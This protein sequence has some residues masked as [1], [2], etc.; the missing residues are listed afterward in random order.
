M[1]IRRALT[2]AVLLGISTAGL[3]PAAEKPKGP[4]APS[5]KLEAPESALATTPVTLAATGSDPDKNDTLRYAWRFDDGVEASGATVTRAFAA[6]TWTATVTVTDR[7]KRTATASAKLVVTPPPRGAPASEVLGATAT[8][9]KTPPTLAALRARISRRRPTLISNVS[10]P[11]TVAVTVR[12]RGS[13]T[14]LRSRT[15]VFGAGRVSV[16]IVRPL[17]RGRYVATA[18]AVDHYGNTGSPVSVALRV[19]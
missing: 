2:V 9:D 18:T 7:T 6:G 5:V 8:S 3:A 14:V 1:P 12:R 10:E 11:A 16:R 13:A 19:R 17:P 4:H 15:I